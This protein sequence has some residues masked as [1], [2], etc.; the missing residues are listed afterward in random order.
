MKGTIAAQDREDT[1]ECA[2]VYDGHKFYLRPLTA[3]A[4][5]DVPRGRY[6]RAVVELETGW[7]KACRYLSSVGLR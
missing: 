7:L 5:S 4:A 3:E 1:V 2:L 6:G